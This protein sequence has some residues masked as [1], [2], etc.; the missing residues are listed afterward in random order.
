VC[1]STIGAPLAPLRWRRSTYFLLSFR[2]AGVILTPI[3][4]PYSLDMSQANVG[5]LATLGADLGARYGW[6][7][8]FGFGG[9]GLISAERGCRA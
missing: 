5:R 9:A 3:S 6:N 4:V 2:Y 1:F 7:A 8:G